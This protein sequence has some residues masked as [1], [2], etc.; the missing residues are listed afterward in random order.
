M[1]SGTDPSKVITVV[2]GLPRSGTSL[3]MQMLAAGGIEPLVDSNRAANADNPRG[4]FEYAPVLRLRDEA[5]WFPSAVGRAVKVVYALLKELP[6]E[7]EVRVVFMRRDLG[8]VVASQRAMLMRS[9]NSVDDLPPDRLIR[10]FQTQVD[11]TLAWVSQQPR[12]R[13][14]EVEHANAIRDPVSVAHAVDVFL[15]G[16]LDLRAMAA[17]PDPALYRQR[18]SSSADPI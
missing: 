3:M 17:V 4:Y 12:L 7:V 6:E 14:L 10:I 8:E 2:S 5:S 18:A 15:G 1:T 16:G 13:L 9:G 11:E